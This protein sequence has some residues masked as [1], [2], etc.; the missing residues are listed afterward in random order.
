MVR[1]E[2]R[3]GERIARLLSSEVHGHRRGPLGRLSVVDADPDV[4]PCPGGAFAYA[5]DV[6]GD[7]EAEAAG[8]GRRIASVF[9]EPERARVAFEAG[10][11]AAVEAVD[12]AGSPGLRLLSSAS[13]EGSAREESGDHGPD[14]GDDD[15]DAVVVAV[16]NGA[17]VKPA[18]RVVRAVAEA[19]GEQRGEPRE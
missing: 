9:A 7:D 3:D 16:E 17:A 10:A 14:A 1:D 15:P 4:E 2:V 6:V 19:V 8:T 13:A 11:A 5:I 18:L 12:A